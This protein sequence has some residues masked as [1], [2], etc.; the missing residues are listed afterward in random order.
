[1][2]VDTRP[3]PTPPVADAAVAVPL[4][5]GLGRRR[6]LTMA[7]GVAG[8]A[9]ATAYL[10]PGWLVGTAQAAEATPTSGNVLVVLFLRGGADG[11]SLVAP[12]ADPTY[13]QQRPEIAVPA[14]A[15]LPVDATFGLH[16]AATNLKGLLDAG[17]L[18]VV[19]AAG[20]PNPTRSHFEAQDFIEK[21]TPTS[22]TTVDGW[23]GRYLRASAATPEATLRGFSSGSGLPASTRGAVVVASPDLASLRLLDAGSWASSST[24]VSTALGAMYS[25]GSPVLRDSAACGLDLV[26]AVGSIVDDA[27]PPADWPTGFGPALW[28]IAKL[29][30][31]GL[32]VEVATADLG[33][34]DTH[35]S[36]GSATDPK[37]RMS[38]LVAD[39][40]ASL[41]AFFGALGAA[42]DRTTV[43]VMTEFGRR[44]AQNGSG[45]LDHGHGQ[46]MLV[47]GAGVSP[48]VKGAWVPL[49]DTDDGDVRVLNDYR[50]VLAELL[51]TRMRPVDLGTVFPAFDAGPAGWVGVTG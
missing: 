26:T 48:G 35:E 51:A 49:T 5:P 44:I 6:F 16:P 12:V 10:R 3:D 21:G 13:A 8:A 50:L 27:A 36:M 45:G 9:C 11:L 7:A 42:A 39:L 41:G 2:P 30:S 14:S 19:P 18:A 4:T 17:R 22:S 46:V 40:D 37:G 29:V 28:P 20:S 47:A 43:V 31:A 38:T 1:M 24:Q 34:W 23:L 15:A 33:G 25:G 32:P